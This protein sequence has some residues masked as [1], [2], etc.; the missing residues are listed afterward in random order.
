M[1]M[2]ANSTIANLNLNPKADQAG[3]QISDS[4]GKSL[5]QRIE[6]VLHEIFEGHEEFLGCTPD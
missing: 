5:L 4:T 3:L 6:G 1:V 2:T